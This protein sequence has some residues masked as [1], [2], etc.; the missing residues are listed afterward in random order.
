MSR[1]FSD[2]TTI[3]VGGPIAHYHRVTSRKQL[4][5]TCKEVFSSPDEWMVLGGGSN[6]V[7]SDAGFDGHVIHIATKGRKL[8]SADGDDV[9]LT[10]QAGEDWDA[11]VAYTVSEGL[12]GLES[13]SGIP[14]LVGASVIQNI[15]AYGYEISDTL[16]HIELIEYPSATTRTVFPDELALGHRTS[17][18]RT[19]ELRGVVGS[20][21]F[22]LTRSAQSKP[23]AYV[24][25]SDALDLDLGGRVPLALLRKTVLELRRSKGMVID[26]SDPDSRSC[27]SFFINPVVSERF[28]YSLPQDTPKYVLNASQATVISLEGEAPSDADFLA[29]SVEGQV[30]LSAAWLIENSGIPKGFQLPGNS[31]RVSIKHTLAITNPGG[32]SAEDVAALARYIKT[33]VLNRFGV[34]LQPEPILIDLALE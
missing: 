10:V 2:L 31:A 21:T 3:G 8:A 34:R 7:V 30:K 9:L 20:V 16:D 12:C 25:V 26:P 18:L 4:V 11:L 1:V 23:I 19:G 29:E 14:G 27:G 28:A 33:Q 22:R 17:A 32:A 13:L 5:A 15:G 24:Q 6:L